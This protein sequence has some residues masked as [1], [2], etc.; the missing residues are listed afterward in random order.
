MPALLR[1]LIVDDSEDDTS[2]I[3][4]KL[5]SGGYDPKWER[6]D[7]SEAMKNA[8]K[9][10]DWDIILCDYKM[11]NF[12]A[13]AALKLAH[14]NK[15]DIPFIVVSGAIGED[16][17]VDLMK[18]GAHDYVMKDKLAKLAVAVERAIREAKIRR[19]K[20][21]TEEM[22]KMSRENFRH[23][24]DD[25]PLGV[26]IVTATGELIYANQEILNIYGYESFEEMKSNP[27][28][29]R[30]TP[31]SCVEHEARKAKR[32]R[33][34]DVPSNYE[35]SIIR[36]DGSIRN[37]EVFRKQ[38]LWNGETQFQALYSDITKRK[39]AEKN[40][41]DSEERYRVVVE[42]AQES[43]LITQHMKIVFANN[44]AAE[45]TGYSVQALTALDL[46]KL[47]H[48]DDINMVVD[49]HSRRLNG[50]K[51]PSIY[52]F[53]IICRDK[54]VK[55]V[56]L[57]ATLIQWE[58]KPAILN[59]L[60]DITARKLLDEERSES[61]KR[62]KET[63][64]ATV[65]SIAMIV[66]TRDPYTTGHQLRVSHLARDIAE[67]MGLTLDQK[68]FIGTAA[69]IHDIGKLSIPSEILSK[70]TKLT[71]LEFEL[72]KTH[73]QSGYNIL[74]DIK[75]PWPVATV[76]LQHH[77]RMNGSGYPNKLK[78]KDI[79]LEA[80]IVAL[81][82]VVEAISSHRPYRP[83]LGINFA[84]DEITKNRVILYDA[85]VVDACLRLFLKKN[86]TF[87]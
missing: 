77:E 67:E 69:I 59:F 47:I 64:D 71:A 11:P 52:S 9:R 5:S 87:Y 70:P 48:P 40:L 78:G 60:T 57:N 58:K 34:E 44:A 85:H 29:K 50:K 16:T 25:S 30:Y 55:W 53:R 14:V 7:S 33:G 80:R 13:P 42:H 62:T 74:K 51:V 8:L 56:E 35:I 61:F 75:F 66:E 39:Q 6:V 76:I 36:K 19:D 15:T 20:K 54:T 84:L 86:Y 81:A 38:V 17:A 45:N 22:L 49:Y 3:I 10:E 2:L 83:T 23:S 12:N 68:E 18:S 24:L 4:R 63:L 82:D 41:R 72:I 31:E 26:R 79:L 28:E 43:I 46:K 32:R 1:V 27:R 21:M 37:L 65:N 73:S